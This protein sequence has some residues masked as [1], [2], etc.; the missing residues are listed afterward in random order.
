MTSQA[1]R[2]RSAGRPTISTARR[3]VRWMPACPKCSRPLTICRPRA[4][5]PTSPAFR[6]RASAK[7]SAA[8]SA[9]L[10][11]IAAMAPASTRAVRT[12]VGGEV[13]P[14]PRRRRLRR[15]VALHAP[16]RSMARRDAFGR[17]W[18]P[19]RFEIVPWPDAPR[20][21]SPWRNIQDCRACLPLS[22]SSRPA[23][24]AAIRRQAKASKGDGHA[25]PKRSRSPRQRQDITS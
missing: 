7:S 4:P 15:S 12:L 17:P 11:Q 25:D 10:G 21:A 9:C 1:A 2:T 16:L 6:P 8:T 14:T 18:M 13:L 5:W 3:R 23:I 22:V 19:S 24:A 20:T